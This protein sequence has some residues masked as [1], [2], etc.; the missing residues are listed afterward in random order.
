[1]KGSFNAKLVGQTHWFFYE[2]DYLPVE[3][4]KVALQLHEAGR[5]G[6]IDQV[7]IFEQHRG[8]GLARDNSSSSCTPIALRTL[9]SCGWVDG[10]FHGVVY[11]G[12]GG[13][14]PPA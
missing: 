7:E 3:V 2:P 5:V 13:R 9:W 12:Y 11:L 1:M 4:G 8:R 6:M 14:S 10:I